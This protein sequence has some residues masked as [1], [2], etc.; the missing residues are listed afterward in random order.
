[1]AEGPTE[2][3]G[4]GAPQSSSKI[5]GPESAPA[6]NDFHPNETPAEFGATGPTLAPVR[7]SR[8]IFS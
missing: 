3:C 1:M 7:E 4:A 5:A 6:S 8:G 2:D